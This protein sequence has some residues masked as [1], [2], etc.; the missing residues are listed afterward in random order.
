[1]PKTEITTDDAAQAAELLAK[2]EMAGVLISD[3]ASFVI[4]DYFARE[5]CPTAALREE[6][7][8]L[9]EALERIASTPSSHFDMRGFARAAIA[10]SQPNKEEKG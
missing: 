10:A 6:N 5:C 2:L 8:R 3:T 7:E 9:W 4:R 1:M